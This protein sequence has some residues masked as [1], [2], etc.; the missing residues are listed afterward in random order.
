MWWAVFAG[1]INPCVCVVLVGKKK[2][3]MCGIMSFLILLFLQFFNQFKGCF[4]QLV[5]AHISSALGS[6]EKGKYGFFNFLFHSG[7]FSLTDV[8]EITE[9]AS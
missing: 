9:F 7:E 8:F 2:F 1:Y 5:T 4:S 6:V 3:F